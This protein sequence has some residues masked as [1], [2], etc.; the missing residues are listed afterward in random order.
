MDLSNTLIEISNDNSNK[1][2]QVYKSNELIESS[3]NLDTSE[4][5]LVYLAMTKLATTILEKNLNIEETQNRIKLAQFDSLF[6]S[7]VEYRKTF[8]I[9]ANNIYETLAETATKLYDEE[10]LYIKENGDF[11]RKRW[12]T[13]CEYD[14]E[15][16]GISLEFNSRMV[17]DLLVF[18]NG[19]TSLLFE[20]FVPKLRG[21]LSF[22]IYELCKKFI[23]I[24]FRDFEIEDL[25]FKLATNDKDY[26]TYALF[27]RAILS[28]IKEIV[29]KT[30]L[31]IEYKEIGK[32]RKTGKV[33]KIRFIIKAQD[34]QLTLFD[35]N[36]TYENDSTK[37]QVK[38]ISELIHYNIS[39][40]QARDILIIALTAI[41][42]LPEL[43]DSNTKVKDYISE[44]VLVCE[45]YIKQ[46]GTKDYIGLLISALK[47]NW[48]EKI[49][50]PPSEEVVCDKDDFKQ[51][52]FHNFESRQ[53]D[54][55]KLEKG[56]LGYE[57]VVIED[58]TK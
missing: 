9:K 3:Y 7:V 28:N 6:I 25:M 15:G 12:V 42:T 44:K 11:G 26:P 30:N 18:D 52:Q 31:L 16:K 2:F 17:K 57:E 35:N 58:V 48:K 51:T 49:V 39:S 43:K 36:E 22:R 19:Y 23:K 38:I 5:R 33:C 8:N 41:D 20:D 14:H 10:V 50:I 46:K 13:T 53:Y 45:E 54:Y 37:N 47:G 21:K 27:K 55:D 29:Q 24:G 1:S 34:Q 40:Q 56:L 4:N 32:V